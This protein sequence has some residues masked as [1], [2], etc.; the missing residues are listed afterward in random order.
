[1]R[2]P[3][4]VTHQYADMVPGNGSQHPMALDTSS[5]GPPGTEAFVYQSMAECHA[6]I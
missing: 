4:N 5:L 2:N 1:M 3:L 6:Q